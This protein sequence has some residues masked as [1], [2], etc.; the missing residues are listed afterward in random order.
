MARYKVTISGVN[1]TNLKTLSNDELEKKLKLYKDGDVSLY[2]ELVEANLRLVLSVVQK[3]SE[4]YD[5]LDDL[6]QVGC[7]GLI[8][9]INNFDLSHNVKFSTYAVP[10]INGEIKRFLRDN[11]PIKIS[12]QLKD[13]A[14]QV[15]KTKESYL[16]KHQKDATNEEIAKILNVD[17]KDIEEALESI[18]P[19]SSIY[20]PVFE[21]NGEPLYLIDQIKVE[22]DAVF[23]VADL[24]TLNKG[25]NQLNSLQKK[26]INDRYYLD[27]T[28]SEI[29]KEFNISQAQVSR[30]EKNAIEVL[31]KY[32]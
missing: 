21:E 18:Q 26:I 19:I 23:K 24:I 9:S 5:N 13:L 10:M 12:R 16:I 7:V 17:V 11:S 6:F 4:R 27:K 29:A 32:F 20:E 31:R 3:F 14:Y 30:L 1:T 2:D 28:Q 22:N 15:L 25:L 8:K